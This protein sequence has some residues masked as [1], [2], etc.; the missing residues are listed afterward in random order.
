[1]QGQAEVFGTEMARSR[2]YSISPRSKIAIFCWFEGCKIMVSCA[3]ITD[4]NELQLCWFE[5]WH[6]T[7]EPKPYG[8][9]TSVWICENVA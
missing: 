7:V 1:M 8:G 4:S 3:V 2:V 9:P 6:S 5:S